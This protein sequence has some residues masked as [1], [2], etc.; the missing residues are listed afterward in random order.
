[1]SFIKFYD[2]ELMDFFIN[3]PIFIGEYEGGE[4]IFYD[5]DKVGVKVCLTIDTYS[6]YI[7]L[8]ISYNEIA[9]FEGDIYKVDKIIKKADSIYIH[10]EY[11]KKIRIDRVNN[12]FSIFL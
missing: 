5:T 10:T 2:D 3:E 8:S 7:N 12:L 4:I 1:M 6:K 9:I 11:K